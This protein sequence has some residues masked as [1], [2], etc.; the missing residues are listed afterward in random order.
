MMSLPR[1]PTFKLQQGFLRFRQRD[2]KNTIIGYRGY[3]TTSLR[4]GRISN[5]A[6]E[7][8]E[9]HVPN[10]A[11]S[12]AIYRPWRLSTVEAV[13]VH[14]HTPDVE[15]GVF[16][17]PMAPQQPGKRSDARE[18]QPLRPR[19]A[20]ERLSHPEAHKERRRRTSQPH[21]CTSG[22]PKYLSS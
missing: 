16:N 14:T 9:K 1:P 10:A 17:A 19:D 4:D 5:Q 15:D 7:E 22:Q 18:R 21:P 2:E 11:F 12:L 6:A 8:I 20:P 3:L 13:F